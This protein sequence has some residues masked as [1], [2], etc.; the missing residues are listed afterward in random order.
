MDKN[1]QT[2]IANEFCMYSIEFIEEN[3]STSRLQYDESVCDEII[4]EFVESG[5]N[6]Y[7]NAWYEYVHDFD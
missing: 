2:C 5:R 7:R 3:D 4:S 1:C 6:E